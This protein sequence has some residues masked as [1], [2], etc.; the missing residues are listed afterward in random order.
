M[1][2]LSIPLL[3][4]V[5]GT[6]NAAETNSAPTNVVAISAGRLIDVVQGRALENQLILIEDG[7]IKS[8]GPR[9]SAAIPA[10]ATRFDLTNATVLPGLMDC[11]T[12]ITSQPENYYDDLF[13]KSPI[14]YA[15]VAHVYARRT[16][17]AGFTTC[18]DV[19]ADE[20]I[21]AALKRAIDS[22]KI[23]GPRLFI[24]TEALSATGGHGDLNGFSP[25]LS[26]KEIGI[27]T[28]DGVDEIRKKVRWNIKYGADWIKILATAGVLSEEESVGAP[29]FSFEEKV[30]S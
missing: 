21:D 22:G 30:G 25:Y 26:F 6:I 27:A 9:A 13:R 20:L 12:H 5:A 4:L 14:D 1:Q 16:L 24:S 3:V 2:K 15:I 28:V 10:N 29:Q 11:H 18:R 8:V 17:E 23:P 19:G 7:V